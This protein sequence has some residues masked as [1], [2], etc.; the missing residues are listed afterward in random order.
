M[1]RAGLSVL[2]GVQE[3]EEET[4]LGGRSRS[5]W[6]KDKPASPSEAGG[7]LLQDLPPGLR[8]VRESWDLFGWASARVVCRWGVRWT[9][10]EGGGG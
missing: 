5:V 3:G 8:I 4:G 2:R 10:A 7:V 1:R 9:E 6:R